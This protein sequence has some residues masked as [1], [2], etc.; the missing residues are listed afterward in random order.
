MKKAASLTTPLTPIFTV[1]WASAAVPRYDATSVIR[2]VNARRFIG[3]PPRR[4]FCCGFLFECLSPIAAGRDDVVEIN[5][6]FVWHADALVPHRR[7]VQRRGRVDPH[8]C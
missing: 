5:L 6:V 4:I 2:P 8:F 3:A 7:R 1:S